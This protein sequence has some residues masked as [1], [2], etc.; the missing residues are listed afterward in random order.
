MIRQAMAIC[1][2][3][4]ISATSVLGQT[5][6]VSAT[7]PTPNPGW[8]AHL[9]E[10]WKPHFYGVL[11]EPTISTKA[12]PE[13]ISASNELY[14]WLLEHPDRTAQAWRKLGVQAVEIQ[15]LGN[16]RFTWKDDQGGELTWQTVLISPSE[17]V[18]YAT[19]KVKP[20]PLMP[21]IPVKAIAV[22][23]HEVIRD[24]QGRTTIRQ[25]IEA[26]LQTESKFAQLIAK[27]IGPAAPKLAE[28]A[29]DQLLLFFAGMTRQITAHPERREELLGDARSKK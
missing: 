13:R 24:A 21:V 18:W 9:P 27:V 4:F 25:W 28:S 19:G 23:H 5:L 10:H 8:M 29:A 2:G 11:N 16:Q 17:H 26:H 20:G 6:P 7:V 14:S 1:A 22:I 15:N 3:L 12:G